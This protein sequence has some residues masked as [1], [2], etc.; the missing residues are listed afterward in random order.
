MSQKTF[1]FIGSLNREAPYFQG[2]RGK[3]IAVYAFDEETGRTAFVC[4]IG[5]IDNPSFL[6]VHPTNGCVYAVSEVLGWN[7]GLVTAFRFDPEAGR[8]IYLNKQP[9]LGSITAHNSFDRSGRFMLVANYAMGDPSELPNQAVAVFPL[10]PD[11]GIAPSVA[12]VAHAGTGPNPE[13]QERSHPHCVQA[14]LDN[15]FVVVADLGID[16]LMTYAFDAGSGALTP[17]PV[18]SFSLAP[19]AGPR[20]FA[21]G[22]DGRS[23]FLINELDSTVCSLLYDPDRGSF[24]LIDTAPALPA[25]MPDSH[26]ADLH[27]H[28]NGR[29]LYGSKSRS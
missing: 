17:G 19:G 26:C 11:G 21:F 22:P 28:P 3:G 7:E 4:D 27:V 14:S 16:K 25:P 10:R 6:S 13:R 18:P 8:L 9:T 12:S 20:H 23:F 2:A 24:A 15:R 29:F 1:V 5:G